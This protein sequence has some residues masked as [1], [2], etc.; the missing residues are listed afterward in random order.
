MSTLDFDQFRRD[1]GLQLT[2]A[3]RAAIL[4]K[5]PLAADGHYYADAVFEGGGVKGTAFLGV[6]RCFSE[7]GIRWKKVAG[8]S[9]GS[10][11]AALLAS[12]RTIDELE[13]LI[14]SLNYEAD[15]LKEKKSKCILNGDPSD[16]LNQPLRLMVNLLLVR[17]LGQYSTEPLKAWVQSALGTLDTF[18]DVTQSDPERALKIVI[19]D[20]SRGEMLVLPDDLDSGLFDGLGLPRASDFSVAEAVRLSSSIPFFFVPGT[21][22]PYTIVDGGI[23]S[24]FPLWIFDVN[25]QLAP[26]DRLP[27]WPTFGF[28]LVENESMREVR[29]A[30][31]VFSGMLQTMMQAKDQYH[32]R[33]SGQGRVVNI[34]TDGVTATEFNLSDEKKKALYKSGYVAA[35]DFLLYEWSWQTHLESR[36]YSPDEIAATLARP[37][38]PTGL[39]ALNA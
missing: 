8:T 10:I 25:Q 24:N 33:K 19:S 20:I 21:L 11:T 1:E 7:V 22:G 16:D 13:E 26:R 27:R 2:D 15:L 4:A 23:L 34:N 31:D 6:L 38:D 36:G 29:N 18:G 32:L 3:D 14:G 35:R 30:V 17:E 37:S 39:S 28:R 12:H 9:A 5:L